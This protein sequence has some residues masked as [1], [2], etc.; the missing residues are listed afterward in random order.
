MRSGVV[1]R[2]RGPVFVVAALVGACDPSGPEVDPDPV[3]DDAN[4]DAEDG[5]DDDAAFIDEVEPNN[6][7]PVTATN[8]LTTATGARGVIADDVDV[9]VYAFASTPGHAYRV[10]CTTAGSPLDC[11]LTVLDDGRGGDAPGDDTIRLAA[12]PAGPDAALTFLALGAGGH[13]VIVRDT[14]AVG[15]PG[16]GGADFAY[17]LTIVDV[18]DD[19]TLRGPALAFPGTLDAALPS[20]TSL[21]LH[22]IDAVADADVVID[23]AARGDADLRAFVVSTT[24]GDWVMRNDDRGADPDPLLDAFFP[25]GGPLLL[26]VEAVADDASDL[27][28][29]VTTS[30]NVR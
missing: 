1:V 18:T 13:F 24:S 28:Y 15:G 8:P 20:P 4:D 17:A 27:G 22:P 23:I 2:S 6:G 7:N 30:G 10:Q 12:H 26:L 11:H 14:R 5:N 29:T 19:P 16:A 25:E 3:S 21:Q 9:D